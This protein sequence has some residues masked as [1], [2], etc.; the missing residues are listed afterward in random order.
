[1]NAISHAADAFAVL[2]A[3]QADLSAFPANMGM[4]GRADQ[5]EVGGRPANLCAGHHQRE[6]LLLHVLAAHLETVSHGGGKTE[7]IAA[8]AFVDALLQCRACIVHGGS[9]LPTGFCELNPRSNPPDL[10]IQF[11]LHFRLF[12]PGQ[13]RSSQRRLTTGTPPQDVSAQLIDVE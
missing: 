11:A 12:V 3:F 2:R 8:Q 10:L 9:P 4:V 13:R 6:M 1:L 5:H 7:L